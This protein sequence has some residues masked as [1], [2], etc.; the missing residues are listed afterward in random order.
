MALT[1]KATNNDAQYEILFTD[2]KIAKGVDVASLKFIVIL[3]CSWTNLDGN[4][5]LKESKCKGT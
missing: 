4:M 3:K 5:R 1:F 2:L